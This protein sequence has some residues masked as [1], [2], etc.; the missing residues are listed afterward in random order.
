VLTAW[1][2]RS[3]LSLEQVRDREQNAYRRRLDC[4]IAAAPIAECRP[5]RACRGVES[6]VT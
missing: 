1:R 4:P 2:A 3:M 5:A 6:A